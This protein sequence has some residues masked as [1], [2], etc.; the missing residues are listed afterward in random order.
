M[1][2][3]ADGVCFASTDDGALVGTD[4]SQRAYFKTAMQGAA[5]VGEVLISLVT[6]RKVVIAASPIYD[7]SGTRVTGVVSLGMDREDALNALGRIKLGETGY[8]FVVDASGLYL[9]HPVKENVLKVDITQVRGMESLA[10]AVGQKRDAVVTYTLG[11]VQHLAAVR[12]VPVTGWS[13]VATAPQ[14]ELH[15]PAVHTRNVIIIV[16]AVAVLLAALVFF[17]FARAFRRS[18]TASSQ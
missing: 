14:S 12:R 17:I 6:G 9:Q 10:Q 1:L 2:I 15:A 16:S 5:N 4:L 7:A 8:V 11:G 13:V 18:P 3:G